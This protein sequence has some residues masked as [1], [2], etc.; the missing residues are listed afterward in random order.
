[1]KRWHWLA[2]GRLALRGGVAILAVA[3]WTP[4]VFIVRSATAWRTFKIFF[5]TVLFLNFE[6]GLDKVGIPVL[7]FKACP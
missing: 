4:G 6:T 1:M 3:W 2:V 7:P 5:D